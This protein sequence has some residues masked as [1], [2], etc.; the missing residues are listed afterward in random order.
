[1]GSALLH[2][3][4]L[5][6]PIGPPRTVPQNTMSRYATWIVVAASL[7]A[8]P[9]PAIDEGDSA[10]DFTLSDILTEEE[11]S[12][13]QFRGRVVVLNFWAYW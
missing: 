12:L 3:P 5:P 6:C 8:F 9:V 11:F 10:P 4:G 2:R 1:M 13:A 7:W